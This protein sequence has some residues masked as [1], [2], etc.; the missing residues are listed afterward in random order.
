M[1]PGLRSLPHQQIGVM[2]FEIVGSAVLHIWYVARATKIQ[3]TEAGNLK[4]GT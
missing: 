4:L 2:H 3:R 1:P